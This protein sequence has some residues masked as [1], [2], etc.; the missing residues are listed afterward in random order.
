MHLKNNLKLQQERLI[1]QKY[2]GEIFKVMIVMNKKTSD[3][4]F[5]NE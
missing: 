3:F 5:E 1:D 4:I 2:M